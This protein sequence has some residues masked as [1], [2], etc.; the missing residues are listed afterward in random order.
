M[1][2]VDGDER[3]VKITESVLEVCGNDHV[4]VTKAFQ[5]QLSLLGK[6]VELFKGRLTSTSQSCP[7]D[8]S[9]ALTLSI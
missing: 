9:D 4:L 1:I 6:E 7:A 2:G 3:L 8:S 5:A